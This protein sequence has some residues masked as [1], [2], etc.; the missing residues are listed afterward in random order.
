MEHQFTKHYTVDEARALIPQ[1]RQ[2]LEKVQLI[3]TRLDKQDDRLAQL[4]NAGNDCGG[5][6]VNDW[7]RNVSA[8]R[9]ILHK[10][11]LLEIQVKD[12]NRGLVDF[13]A[14]KGGREVFLCWEMDED[15]VE[16]WHDLDTGYAGR[17]KLDE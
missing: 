17:E 15:D 1:L 14:I 5:P 6:L 4:L 10:F 16:Y 3:R 8:L 13:P 7:L 2:W 11:H 12:I 9:K